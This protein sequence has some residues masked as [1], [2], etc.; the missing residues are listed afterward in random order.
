MFSKEELEF[1]L[2]HCL[3]T[4]GRRHFNEFVTRYEFFEHI[5]LDEEMKT[6]FMKYDKKAFGNNSELL[7]IYD[8]IKKQ[9]G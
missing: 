2:Y 9:K 5:I 1:L 8:E 6:F 7:K 3:G 4:I